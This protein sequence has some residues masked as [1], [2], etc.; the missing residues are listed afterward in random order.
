MIR[1]GNNVTT[2]DNAFQIGDLT[3]RKNGMQM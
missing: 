3:I 1:N 2:I